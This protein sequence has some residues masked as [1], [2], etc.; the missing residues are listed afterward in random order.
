MEKNVTTLSGMVFRN[1]C[2]TNFFFGRTPTGRKRCFSGMLAVDLDKLHQKTAE[3]ENSPLGPRGKKG[4]RWNIKILSVGKKIVGWKNK[5]LVG[6]KTVGEKK[7]SVGEFPLPKT[8]MSG[9]S[10][11]PC[12]A[13]PKNS[14]GGKKKP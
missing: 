5:M 6:K 14:R 2:G 9:M 8:D 10:G 3:A 13:R 11:I 4:V 12:N 1:F 7:M